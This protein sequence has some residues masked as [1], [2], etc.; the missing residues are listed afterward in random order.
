MSLR[1]PRNS[2]PPKPVPVAALVLYA[3]DDLWSRWARLLFLEKDVADS[4]IERIGS[5]T[6]LNEDL[7]VLNPEQRLPALADREVMLT[8]ARV[9]SEYLED[10]YPHPR[11]LPNEPLG[12]ARARMALDRFEQELF[13]LLAAATGAEKA[14]ARSAKT[15]LNQVLTASARSFSARGWFLGA[16]FTLADAAWAV[17][18]QGVFALGIEP[19]LPVRDYAER[20]AKRPSVRKLFAAS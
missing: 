4:R 6:P 3:G 7:L 16:E 1:R 18:L 15:R 11:V 17:W 5:G 2:P 20:L 12:R 14:A 10:R 19:P 8:G 13:P 9:I